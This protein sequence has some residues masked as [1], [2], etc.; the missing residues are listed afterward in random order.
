MQLN[1]LAPMHL[2]RLLS[3]AMKERC[4]GVIINMC[5]VA[6]VEPMTQVWHLEQAAAGALQ[7]VAFQ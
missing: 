7:A 3:P 4:S 5:S 6:G 2:T 1:L